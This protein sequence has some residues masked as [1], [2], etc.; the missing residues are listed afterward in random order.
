MTIGKIFLPTQQ[1]WRTFP[2]LNSLGAF[3]AR[4][5]FS[6][7]GIPNM[8]IRLAHFLRFD[9][10][11]RLAFQKSVKFTRSHTFNMIRQLFLIV[12]SLAVVAQIAHGKFGITECEMKRNAAVQNGKN[13][14]FLLSPSRGI[15]DTYSL[16]SFKMR[17]IP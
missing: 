1:S 16:Y 4:S 8:T 11:F 13:N 17:N 9:G 7:D 2:L 3:L 15:S 14:V 6:P 10:F 5:D 12:L